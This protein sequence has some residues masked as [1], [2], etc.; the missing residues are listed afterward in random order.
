MK[1]FGWSHRLRE[2]YRKNTGEDTLKSKGYST[3]FALCILIGWTM[4]ARTGDPRNLHYVTTRQFEQMGHVFSLLFFI[5]GLILSE[6]DFDGPG[7][8]TARKRAEEILGVKIQPDPFFEVDLNWLRTHA[9]IKLEALAKNLIEAE[10]AVGRQPHVNDLYT[11]RMQARE[12]LFN[13][14]RLLKNLNLVEKEWDKYFP[15]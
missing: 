12:E 3:L 7:F 4:I 1:T 8:Y 11:V 10:N 2:A 14:H 13:A 5:G 15:N 9:R 6:L